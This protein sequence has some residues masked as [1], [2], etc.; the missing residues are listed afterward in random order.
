MSQRWKD[1]DWKI[2]IRE[3]CVRKPKRLRSFK[4]MTFPDG[5]LTS[6]CDLD[7]DWKCVLGIDYFH[8]EIHIASVSKNCNV[9]P[10][11]FKTS[12]T[13]ISDHYFRNNEM[14]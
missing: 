2:G 10:S 6:L 13:Y 9:C 14:V 12:L 8:A 5:S 7:N 3:L 4:P 1:P 11:T